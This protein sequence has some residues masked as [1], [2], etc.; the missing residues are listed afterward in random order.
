M[1]SLKALVFLAWSV[2]VWSGSTQARAAPCCGGGATI[3]SLITGDDQY[4]LTLSTSYGSVVGDAPATGTAIF[5]SPQDNEVSQNTELSGARLVSDRAQM[6][7]SLPVT[8]RARGYGNENDSRSGLGDLG[9]TLAYEALPDW[10]YSPWRPHTFVFL[11]QIF[12]TGGSVYDLDSTDPY[13]LS[14]RGRGFLT[15][16]LGALF[17]K[18]WR[19]FDASLSL[20]ISKSWARSWQDLN[21][22]PSWG[23]SAGLALGWSPGNSSYRLGLSITPVYE[24]PM[25]IR[26]HSTDNPTGNPTGDSLGDRSS[27]S[28]QLVWNSGLS[29]SKS[30]AERWALS[31]AYT[32]QTLLGPARNVSLSRTLALALNYRYER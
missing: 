24:G 20:V 9:V 15:T 10:D 16:S 11:Q 22:A 6:G 27:S 5:R 4:Q 19:S 31:L 2:L 1:K 23:T 14:A 30:F 18:T 21:V 17:L 8:Y 25:S 3:P 28:E 29:L 13:G 32:D 12:P 26:T 7:F